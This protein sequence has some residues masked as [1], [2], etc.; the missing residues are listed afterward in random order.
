[1]YSEVYFMTVIG[2]GYA[3]PSTHKMDPFLVAV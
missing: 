2:I 3:D 1:M